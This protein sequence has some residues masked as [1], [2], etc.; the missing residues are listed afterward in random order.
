M[1]GMYNTLFIIRESYSIVERYCELGCGGGNNIILEY[2][3]NSSDRELTG[4]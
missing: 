2:D 4:R 3:T 1:T